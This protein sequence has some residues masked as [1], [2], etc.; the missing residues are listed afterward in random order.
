MV[1][2]L[3]GRGTPGRSKA[4]H[5]AS[6]GRLA[7]GGCL[8]D[9]VAALRQSAGSRPWMDLDRVGAFGHSGGGFAAARA[10]LDFP[11]V[12]RAG[13]ALSGSHDARFFNPGFVETYDGAADPQAIPIGP[14]LLAELFA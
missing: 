8:A 13:V 14:E 1:T 6:Y 4:F 9:H 12:Y 3:D 5:D 7:D 11:E 2:A 10:M